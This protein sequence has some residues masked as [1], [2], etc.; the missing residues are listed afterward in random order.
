MSKQTLL[1]TQCISFQPR[2]TQTPSGIPIPENWIIFNAPRPMFGSEPTDQEPGGNVRLEWAGE[3]VRGCLF[4]AV[5]PDDPMAYW[6]A[7]ENIGLDGYVVKYVS[8]KDVRD[9]FHAY[10]QQ[11]CAQYP[12]VQSETELL[13]TWGDIQA[14]YLDHLDRNKI[15]IEVE[16]RPR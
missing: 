15:Q 12:E 16:D 5:N 2:P 3:W 4:S 1:V 10:Y 11:L 7:K 14:T 13:Y 6:Q 9:W 8:E